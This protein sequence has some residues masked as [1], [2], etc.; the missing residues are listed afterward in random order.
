MRSLSWV[1]SIFVCLFSFAVMAPS[2]LACSGGAGETIDR[3]LEWT[4]IAVKARP[5]MVDSVRQNGILAV[6]SYLIGGPG[7]EFLFFVQHEPIN[8]ERIL[9]GDGACEFFQKELYVGEVGYYFLSRRP[10]GSYISTRDW[11]EENYVSFP[12][13][14][15]IIGLSLENSKFP[16]SEL[17]VQPLRQDSMFSYYEVGEEAFVS[18]LAEMTGKTPTAPDTSQPYPR[19]APLKI[20]TADGKLYILPIDSTV[21]VEVTDDLFRQMMN[22]YDR[23]DW[24]QHLLRPTVCPGEDCVTIS[25]DGMYWAVPG[26]AHVQRRWQDGQVP[27]PQA[28]LFSPT[29]RELAIWTETT[30]EIDPVQQWSYRDSTVLRS[31]PLPGAPEALGQAAWSHDGHQIAYSDEQGVWLVD[32]YAPD[33]PPRLLLPAEDGI[34]PLARAFSPL[35]RYVHIENGNTWLNVNVVTGEHLPSG[36]FSPNERLL[37]AFDPAA[38]PFNLQICGVVRELSCNEAIGTVAEQS[39]DTTIYADQF[40]AVSWRDPYSFMALVCVKDDMSACFV[41]RRYLEAEEY[42]HSSEDYQQGTG[43]ADDPLYD[44]LVVI[45]GETQIAINNQTFDLSSSLSAPIDSVEWLPGL[46]YWR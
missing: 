7:P 11:T 1:M 14:D 27:R 19:Y 37:L 39:S 15:S 35:G 24:N 20:S 13:P 9:R 2:A 44:A 33:L 29:G 36:L 40:M 32:V 16:P 45:T 5:V 46:F 10:D 3:L 38:A 28:F 25:S 22:N 6:E 8:V 12:Q 23:P 18:V 41:D 30:L 34:I 26:S 17:T 43:Y 31:I 42:W 21:P 4:Q